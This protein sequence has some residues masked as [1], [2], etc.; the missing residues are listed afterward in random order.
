MNVRHLFASALTLAALTGCPVAPA[1]DPLPEPPRIVSFTASP[2]TV[3]RGGT[4]T[5][6]WETSNA[7]TI[8]VV[9]LNRGAIPGVADKSAGDVQVVVSQPTVF[10][11]SAKNSRG[12]RV[13][14]VASVNVEG[15]Q[16]AAIVFTAYPPVVR[17]GEKGLLVW[18]AP[19]AQQVQIAPMGG[20]AIDLKGQKTSGSIEVDPTATETTYVLTADGVTRNVVLVR[21]QGINEFKSSQTQVKEG[22]SLALSWKTQNASKVRLSSPGRGVLK[23]TTDAAEMSMGSVMDQ[24]GAQIDGSAVNYVLEVEGRGPV[25]TKVVTVYFGSAPQVLTVTAPDF[26]K[27]NLSFTVAWT[28]VGADRVEVRTGQQIVY[29]T[30]D[31]I[32]V[33]MGS[34]SIPAPAMATDFTLAAISTPSGATA[35]RNFKVTPV[36]DV[37]MPTFTAAP[38][39]IATGGT[40][41]TLTWSAPGAVRARILEN[42][43]TTVAAF[44]GAT[45][46]AGTVTVYPNRANTSYE[47]RA[48]NTLEPEVKRATSVTVTTPA[49]LAAAD[50]GTIYQSQNSAQLSWTVGGAASKLIGFGTPTAE[51][52]A[53]STGFVDIVTTGT[54]L[55]LLPNTN[56]ALVS[57]TPVNFETFLGSRRVENTVW[58]STNGFLQFSGVAVTNAR[59][60]P[61]TI[62]NASTIPEDFI[63]PLW[64]DLELG[65]TGSIWWAVT[66][67]APLQ[68]LVVQWNE[69]QV[70]GQPGS[71]LTFQARVHQAGAVT[72]EYKT[73]TTTA[74]VPVSIGYQGPP[75]LGYAHAF[76]AA[77]ADGGMSVV[78]PASGSALAFGGASSSPAV[79][80]T[81]AAPGSALVTIG[82]GAIRVQYDQIVKPTDIF[83]SEIMHRPNP[84]VPQGQWLELANFSNA[85]IDVTGW[86]VSSSD[87]GVLTTLSGGT[88][89][90]PRGYLVVGQTS[91]PLLNDG[92]PVNL[93]AAPALSLVPT[94][95]SIR[96]SNA[97]G[98]SNTLTYPAGTQGVSLTVDQGPFVLRNAASTAPFT[99]GLCSSRPSQTF[100]NLSPSQRGTPGASGNGSCLGYTMSTIPVRFKDIAASGRVV[101]LSSLDESVAAVDVTI[102][103]V[104]VYGVSTNVVTVSTNG[105][106]VPKAYSGSSN[107][108]NKVSPSSGEPDVGGVIA[109]FWDD[110]RFLT[111]RPGSTLLSQRFAAGDD[112]NEPRAHWIIQWN[113]AERFLNND[114]FTFQVKLFDSGDIEYHYATMTSATTD[115]YGNGNSAT[116]WLEAPEATPARALVFSINRPTITSNMAIRFTR[117]P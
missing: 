101:A 97:Q 57:F 104:S 26:V 12:A 54:R 108:T 47:L 3:L 40:P 109:P 94:G 93:I 84:A 2:A 29:R 89:I 60:A 8:E 38:T 78:F 105:W 83:I 113:R 87:G 18:N 102:A 80:S 85:T 58:V 53:T 4:T 86:Q 28:T 59:A 50:G 6:K 13:S 32:S 46:G 39:T 41:V 24:L 31:G 16:A 100:G 7:T 56:D 76:Q 43:E 34:V 112:P 107:F 48:T 10:V 62:P 111:S 27:E 99:S 33:A 22:D 37:G 45:A 55:E 70:R 74:P 5:L 90:A 67:T 68:E 19:N 14:A 73:V 42:G 75:G 88:S 20:Q 115:N 51:V 91:D 72:F 81:L 49:T 65:P 17:P 117:I 21:G 92:L 35:T 1:P 98:F 95:S 77:A 116:I 36:T 63:A 114:D 15:V 23:E 69:L 82:T 110:L 44:E 66:G 25:E 52:R 103:P 106:L 11:V 96:L 79:V 9:D 30:P 61:A 64:A 71:S